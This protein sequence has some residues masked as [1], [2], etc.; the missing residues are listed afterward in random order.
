MAYWIGSGHLIE[1]ILVLTALEWLVLTL[2]H[3]WM[4]RGLD[5]VR[6]ASIL[7]PGVFLLVAVRAAL[8]GSDWTWI[9]A[10]LSAALV[11]AAS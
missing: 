5:P 1:A 7:L 8:V 3:R 2:Y 10:A 11:A 6:L 9:A 4:G